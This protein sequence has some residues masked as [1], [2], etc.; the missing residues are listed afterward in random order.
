MSRSIGV[1]GIREW[2]TLTSSTN[3]KLDSID[4]NFEAN[5]SSTSVSDITQL[6]ELVAQLNATANRY[7][8][9]ARRDVVKMNTACERIEELDQ[10]IRD[11]W[12]SGR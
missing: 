11:A 9:V 1:T 4:A 5:F 2:R 10:Q 8:D 12:G 3:R 7:S 6:T